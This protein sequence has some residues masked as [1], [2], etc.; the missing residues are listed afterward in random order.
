MGSG[1]P[2]GSLR[3]RLRPAFCAAGGGDARAQA[4][5]AVGLFDVDQAVRAQPVQS[6]AQ[7]RRARMAAAQAQ[8]RQAAVRQADAGMGRHVPLDQRRQQ[9]VAGALARLAPG[10]QAAVVRHGEAPA[11]F[12]AGHGN[13]GR[14]ALGVTRLPRTQVVRQRD[15]RRPVRQERAAAQPFAHG[16]SSRPNQRGRSGAAASGSM[17][18]TSRYMPPAM[19]STRLCV[20]MRDARRRAGLHAQQPGDMAGAAVQVRGGD[21]DVIDD[22][23]HGAMVANAGRVR[24]GTAERRVAVQWRRTR[25]S[26][27][28]ADSGRVGAARAADPDLHAL[29]QETRASMSRSSE[30]FS[31]L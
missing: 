9:A 27:D 23:F 24:P 10:R 5:R 20:P 6:L 13:G 14:D 17:A 28:D 11:Q 25:P 15:A 18:M 3:G 19:P 22:E 7:Q 26:G 21:D 8:Q 29:V 31:S 4:R 12:A 2:A 1:R 30:M 16:R